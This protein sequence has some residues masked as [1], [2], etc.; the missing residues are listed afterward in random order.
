[1]GNIYP[2]IFEVCAAS[3]AVRTALGSSPVRLYLFGEAPQ[4][5]TATYA[6]WQTIGGAPD[7]YLGNVPDADRYSI[8]VDVYANS[9]NDARN[10]VLSLRDAIEPVAYITGWRGEARDTDT[11]KFR[12]SF[13]VDWI[14]KR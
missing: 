11:K 14:V 7:N 4:G 3:P 5:V 12:S 6:V 10:A 8:Q 13:D 9:A 2:P 1:M